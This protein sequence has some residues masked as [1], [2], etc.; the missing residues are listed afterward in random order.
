V[1]EEGPGSPGHGFP[2]NI[3]DYAHQGAH[4]LP[5]IENSFHAFII[6]PSLAEIAYR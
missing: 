5:V 2:I 1:G 4:T 6:D 3:P